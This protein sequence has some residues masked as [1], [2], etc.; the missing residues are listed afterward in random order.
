ML[1]LTL[2][3]EKAGLLLHEEGHPLTCYWG[4]SI[5]CQQHS[6][7]TTYALAL[8]LANDIL[9]HYKLSHITA[10]CSKTFKSRSSE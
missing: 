4:N 10:V 8:D 3:E 2:S 9:A 1:T 6:M 5:Q 7:F